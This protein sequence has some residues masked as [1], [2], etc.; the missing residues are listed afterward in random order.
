MIVHTTIT[1][2]GR[3][4]STTLTRATLLAILRGERAVRGSTRFEREIAPDYRGRLTRYYH[5][6][7]ATSGR[8]LG[9]TI[10]I[11]I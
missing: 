5:R 6:V 2:S 7:C 9:T 8:Y 11:L 1:G 3:T 4:L 10:S